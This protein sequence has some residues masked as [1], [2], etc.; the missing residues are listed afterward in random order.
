MDVR[1]KEGSIT[2]LKGGVRLTNTLKE[3]QPY[4]S[5]ILTSYMFLTCGW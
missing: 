4:L 1:N 5:L 3:C 2:L